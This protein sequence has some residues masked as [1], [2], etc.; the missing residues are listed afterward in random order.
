M[1]D[2]DERSLSP[3]RSAGTRPDGRAR[4]RGRAAVP[5]AKLWLADRRRPRPW[6]QNAARCRRLDLAAQREFEIF[7]VGKSENLMLDEPALR[8]AIASAMR[9]SLTAFCGALAPAWATSTAT[10]HEASRVVTESARLV[11]M[12]GTRAP[13]T[14]PAASA[15]ARNERLFAS[16][17]PASRSGTTSTF[18]RPATG[19]RSS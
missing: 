12:I 9:A 4:R 11:R 16:M 3:A 10:A 2:A 8:T 17:L 18:A 14:M 6:P 19:E 7:A 1:A 5:S 13:S 15:S